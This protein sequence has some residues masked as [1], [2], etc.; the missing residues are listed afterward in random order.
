MKDGV[1]GY[2][3]R[4][5]AIEMAIQGAEAGE[6]LHVHRNLPGQ[7]Q[8]IDACWCEPHHILLAG[9]ETAEELEA[10]VLAAEVIH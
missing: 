10:Q 5:D 3:S 8:A 6:T 2:P 1:I 9:D 4:L 7:H